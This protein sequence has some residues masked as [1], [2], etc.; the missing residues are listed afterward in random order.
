VVVPLSVLFSSVMPKDLSSIT[1]SG[2]NEDVGVM[3][4]LFSLL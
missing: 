4:A 3:S 1:S 2:D